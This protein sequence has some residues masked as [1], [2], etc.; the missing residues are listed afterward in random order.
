MTTDKPEPSNQSPP[1]RT[2]NPVLREL[3]KNPCFRQ[4]KS[5]G[6]AVIIT[7]IRPPGPPAEPLPP[8]E[9]PPSESPP[10]EPLAPEA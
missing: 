9:T 5:T 2:M 7:G 8:A 3:L 6:G 1:R 10:S 4:V